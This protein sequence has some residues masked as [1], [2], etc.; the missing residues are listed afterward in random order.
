[1][2]AMLPL[3][4]IL[5]ML[6]AAAIAIVQHALL[7]CSRGRLEELAEKS[8]K[9][10]AKRRTA[11]I[12]ADIPG[13]HAAIGLWRVVATFAFVI[14]A[15]AWTE[16]WAQAAADQP[17]LLGL[18]VAGMVALVGLLLLFWLVIVVLPSSIAEHTPERA[19]LLTSGGLRLSH[20]LVLPVRGLLLVFD[21]GVRRLAGPADQ[22]PTEQLEQEILDVVEEYGLGTEIG[23]E[24]RDMLEKIVEFRTTTVEQVMTP[25]T[26]VEAIEYSDDLEAVKAII[27]D[28]GHSRVPVYEGNLDHVVGLLYAKDLLRWIITHGGNGHPF[29]LA[30]ILRPVIF[31]PETKTVRELL[32]ELLAQRVHLAMVADEYGGTAGLVSIE[33]IIEEVF[34]EIADEYD[35]PEDDAPGVTLDEPNNAAD[36]DARADIDDANDLMESLGIELPESDDYDTVGGFVVV[37]L[38]RIPQPG[39]TFTHSADDATLNIE[40]LE[41][42]P[43][44]VKRIRVT[45]L[46]D[47]DAAPA[48]EP[49]PEREAS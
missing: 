43:T 4:T 35:N 10:S 16:H 38:G 19:V 45:R 8:K 32:T 9:P 34:G 37:S 49:L 3:I 11:A 23:E 24:E 14:A 33:D 27:N 20:A 13:H 29:V 12:M 21:E 46:D 22:T 25:R 36:I 28:R 39:D 6:V 5:A 7:E 26:D 47:S 18:S 2:N 48:Q 44:R 40:V 42:E 31:V 30:E 1:M 17:Q 41:A 15:V